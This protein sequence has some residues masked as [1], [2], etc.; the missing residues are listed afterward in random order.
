MVIDA[1]NGLHTISHTNFSY[2]WV[3][4]RSLVFVL[5]RERGDLVEKSGSSM[6]IGI[7]GK[8]RDGQL[9]IL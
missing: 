7:G 6:A 3:I 1:L 4:R 9:V 5:G 2:L 8:I